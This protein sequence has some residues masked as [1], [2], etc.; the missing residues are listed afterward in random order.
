[1]AKQKPAEQ[2]PLYARVR[3]VVEA[4]GLSNAEVAKLTGWHEL[5]VWR[6]LTGRTDLG[7]DDMEALAAAVGESV[8]TLYR[9]AIA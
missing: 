1:M 9:G 3:S 4:K 2:P 8:E 6:L 5:R 7:A